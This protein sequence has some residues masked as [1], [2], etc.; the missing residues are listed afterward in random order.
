MNIFIILDNYC[1]I[2]FQMLRLFLLPPAGY[3]RI[4][5]TAFL[6]AIDIWIFKHFPDLI[7]KKVGVILF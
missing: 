2:D 7:G 1:Q 4:G 6:R 5:F 3:E